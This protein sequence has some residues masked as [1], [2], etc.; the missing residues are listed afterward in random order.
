MALKRGGALNVIVAPRGRGLY[1]RGT[2]PLETEIKVGRRNQAI[3]RWDAPL[4]P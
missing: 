3:P 4:S 1:F 2:C